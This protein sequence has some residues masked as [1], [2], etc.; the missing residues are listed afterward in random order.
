MTVVLYIIH[1]MFMDVMFYAFNVYVCYV[2][3][4]SM[5]MN[6]MFYDSMF[7]FMIQCL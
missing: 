3:C 2:L 7:M 5:F 6:V 4:Y 1:S